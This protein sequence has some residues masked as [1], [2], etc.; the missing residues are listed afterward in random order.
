MLK[1]EIITDI[2]HN[3]IVI[4][5]SVFFAVLFFTGVLFL[6][7]CAPKRVQIP[8]RN[9]GVRYKADKSSASALNIVRTA[10]AQVGRP[11]KWGG[12]SPGEGFDCSGLVWWVY[13]QNG[14]NLPRMTVGQI[15]AGRPVS[16]N[17]LQAGDIV[18]FD[19]GTWGKTLHEGIYAGSNR[20][21]IH[22]PKSGNS[23]REE[24]ISKSYWRDR[25]VIGR[26]ILR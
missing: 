17:N 15:K 11:Y 7:G 25:F 26:R 1:L 6:Q 20:F 23:V 24:S 18:F 16:Y 21:F 2:M 10:R 9:A 8:S 12:K 5:L 19:V 14:I 4:R 22:S 13:R 3:I